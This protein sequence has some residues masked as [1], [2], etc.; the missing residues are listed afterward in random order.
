MQR[1]QE[2]KDKIH[3]RS[4]R[5]RNL[6]NVLRQKQIENLWI[7][8]SDEEKEKLE[9]CIVN[10][11]KDGI[12]N[13]WRGH[14]K[15]E[16]GEQSYAQLKEIA[17]KQKIKDYSRKTKVNL[18]L[19]LKNKEE[20]VPVDI[21]IVNEPFIID[22]K[23]FITKMSPLLLEAKVPADYLEFPNEA[24]Y[25]D[26]KILTTALEWLQRVYSFEYK[27]AKD[28]K[29]LLTEEMWTRYKNWGEFDEHQEALL[30]TERL[31]LLKKAIVRADR[32]D[33]FKRKKI[34]RFLKKVKEDL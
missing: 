28:I 33:L 23:N 11:D 15:I 29:A 27:N 12:I 9:L 8:S 24:K 30:L 10:E 4:K 25:F 21:L 34:E 13:W 22:I 32:P 18:L 7:L 20:F 14:S 5:L 19:A 6:D 17:R 31:Q 16:F 2:L 1:L 26:T 3:L